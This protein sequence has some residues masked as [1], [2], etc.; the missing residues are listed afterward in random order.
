MKKASILLFGLVSLITSW[1]AA[2]LAME[3]EVHPAFA[4]VG[5]L[6]SIPVGHAEY[7]QRRP[8]DKK[9]QPDAFTRRTGGRTDYRIDSGADN[10]AHSVEGKPHETERLR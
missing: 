3:K 8:P 1:G 6:T 9:A 7:C 2:G 5:S 4:S 10:G